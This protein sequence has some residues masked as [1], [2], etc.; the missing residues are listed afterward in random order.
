MRGLHCFGPL[1]AE[2]PMIGMTCLGCNESMSAGDYVTLIPIGPGADEEER[3]DARAGRPY[4]AVTVPVH[5]ACGT[6]YIEPP[7]SPEGRIRP[8]ETEPPIS[9]DSG[10]SDGGASA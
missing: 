7:R 3:K 8:H 4:T 9:P 2:H 5:W 10:D 6:G 1:V